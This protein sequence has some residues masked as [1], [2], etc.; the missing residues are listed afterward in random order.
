MQAPPLETSRALTAALRQYYAHVQQGGGQE[1]IDVESAL[2]HTYTRDNPMYYLEYLVCA[3]CAATRLV[4]ANAQAVLVEVRQNVLLAEGDGRTLSYFAVLRAIGDVE[5]I[6]DEALAGG[7]D[8]ARRFNDAVVRLAEDLA[9]AM[10][11]A[12]LGTAAAAAEHA[13]SL[14]CT[15][16]T[17]KA[18]FRGCRGAVTLDDIR[19][20][21][22]ALAGVQLKLRI[23]DE[24]AACLTEQLEEFVRARARP[25]GADGA[26][27]VHARG[28]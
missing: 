27:A 17:L 24:T 18:D 10:I 12:L 9:E 13:R 6:R 11:V 25:C 16:E 2:E 22:H 3:R 8:L 4:L 14:A 7:R 23:A 19:F 15:L 20:C 21:K 1:R 26:C 28:I 5:R